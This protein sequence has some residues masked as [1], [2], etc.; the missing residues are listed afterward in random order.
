MDEKRQWIRTDEQ[1]PDEGKLVSVRLGSRR[2]V[3]KLKRYRHLWFLED[4][5]MYVYY[6]P[7]HWLSE[8]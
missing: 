6:V 7:T 8:S 3:Q 2:V 1:L 5:S 4:G